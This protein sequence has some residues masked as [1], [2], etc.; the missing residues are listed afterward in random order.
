KRLATIDDAGDMRLLLRSRAAM[1]QKAAADHD[2][3]KIGL[4]HQRLAERLHHDHGFDGPCPEAAIG[5]RE[6][7]S[8]QALLGELAP[9]RAAPAALLFHILLAAV[10]I[11][12]VG[13]KP[14][15]ALFQEPLLLGQIEIHVRLLSR[16]QTR[17]SCPRLSRAS[18]SLAPRGKT[19]M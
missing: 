16:Y 14:V 2:G 6:R 15:D 9:D 12:G 18:T 10:E 19:W 17:S 7:Q 1:A 13:Q 4:Q 5:F 11:I 3:R 8:K